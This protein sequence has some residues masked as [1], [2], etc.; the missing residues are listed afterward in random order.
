MTVEHSHASARLW[1]KN[2]RDNG[3]LQGAGVDLNRNYDTNWDMDGGASR[4]PGSETYKG[5]YAASEPEVQALTAYFLKQARVVGAIDFHSFSQLILRPYGHT[6]D[7]PPHEDHLKT[8]GDTMRDLIRDVHGK[9]YTSIASIG[10]YPTTGTASDWFYESE[11]VRER[12]GQ[13]VYGYT[14]ELRP[15]SAMGAGGFLLSPKEIIP[16]G[17][18]IFPA[19]VYFAKYAA[20]HPLT[21]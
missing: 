16:T 5:P 18:E 17:E 11:A 1:R 20:E 9:Q 4:M 6:R 14:I 15:A 19:V 8:V 2:R 3:R 10:L 7:L 21:E 13:R 12:M